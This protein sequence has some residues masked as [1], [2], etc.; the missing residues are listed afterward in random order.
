MAGVNTSVFTDQ[1]R[2]KVNRP[3]RHKTHIA[4]TQLTPPP[5][6]NKR[7]P[8]PPAVTVHIGRQR[9]SK[10]QAWQTPPHTRWR[11]HRGGGGALEQTARTHAYKGSR[12]QD[13]LHEVVRHFG[14]DHLP[15]Q[16]EDSRDHAHV[17]RVAGGETLGALGDSLHEVLRYKK[18]ITRQNKEYQ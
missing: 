17:P 11:K 7:P 12:T 2:G 5:P 18:K 13:Y 10:S 16:P 9:R 15:G 3:T 14:L 6:P 1:G 8:P 4:P